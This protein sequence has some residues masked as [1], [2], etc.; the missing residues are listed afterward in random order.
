MSS[1]FTTKRLQQ[2]MQNRP[3]NNFHRIYYRERVSFVSPLAN[4]IKLSYN[5]AKNIF[6]FFKGAM[7]LEWAGCHS[8]ISNE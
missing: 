7:S 3:L 5:I 4:A 2:M 1:S 6:F 8:Q